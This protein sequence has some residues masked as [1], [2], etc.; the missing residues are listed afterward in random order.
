MESLLTV[1]DICTVAFAYHSC[2]SAVSWC[3]CPGHCWSNYL[4]QICVV[5]YSCDLHDC[6]L[7]YLTVFSV[8][9]HPLKPCMAAVKDISLLATDVSS[10]ANVVAL[11]VAAGHRARL[12][13][14]ATVSSVVVAFVVL[15]ASNGLVA[16]V[17]LSP[18]RVAFSATVA[19]VGGVVLATQV[20]PLALAVLVDG[21]VLALVNTFSTFGLAGTVVPLVSLPAVVLVIVFD[22]TAVAV[23]LVVDLVGTFACVVVVSTFSVVAAV[24]AAFSDGV[25][26][27][28]PPLHAHAYLATNGHISCGMTVLGQFVVAV[29]LPEVF[30]VMICLGVGPAV[31]IAA[32]VLVCH[33]VIVL[34]PMNAVVFVLD[35]YLQTDAS[36]RG[37]LPSAM[38]VLSVLPVVSVVLSAFAVSYFVVV[39]A[40]VVV[41]VFPTAAAL[42]DF[43]VLSAVVF[44]TVFPV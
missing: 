3:S 41:F 11:V 30:V 27:S 29:A 22:S 16:V 1:A 38:L 23:P 9:H 28:E 24:V 14:P 44:Q 34:L 10:G 42:D 7:P 32:A 43:V 33:V 6:F 37:V 19:A 26:Y 40:T 17:L 35:L 39:L 31:G 5:L 8:P 12:L 21:N 25:V 15:V 4:L 36:V 2:F 20:A 13:H 18:S